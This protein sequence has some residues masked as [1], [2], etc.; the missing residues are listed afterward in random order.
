MP[1]R[2]LNSNMKSAFKYMSLQGRGEA[3]SF[4]FFL[5]S[6]IMFSGKALTHIEIHMTVGILYMLLLE[7]V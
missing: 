4:F 3:P 6:S 1:L 2:H 7:T 5:L